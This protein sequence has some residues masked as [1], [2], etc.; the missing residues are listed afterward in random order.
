[1]SSQSV[2]APPS[3]LHNPP[4]SSF[5][6]SFNSKVMIAAM[7]ILFIVVVFVVGLHI[8][9]KWFWR[10]G[11]RSTVSAY[12]RYLWRRHAPLH[13]VPL[14]LIATA[15]AISVQS[16]LEAGLDPLIINSLPTFVYHPFGQDHSSKETL[17]ECAVCL[18]EF[19]PLEKG[20]LLPSCKHSFHVAC[21]DM[22]FRSHSTCP[23]CR[24]PVTPWT[25]ST[26]ISLPFRNILPASAIFQ[27]EIDQRTPTSFPPT[28]QTPC[29]NQQIRAILSVPGPTHV[30]SDQQTVLQ[31]SSNQ[32]LSPSNTAYRSALS[33]YKH[34]GC[35]SSAPCAICLTMDAGEEVQLEEASALRCQSLSLQRTDLEDSEGH[36]LQPAKSLSFRFAIKRL[37]SRDSS[38]G[39]GRIFPSEPSGASPEQEVESSMS[40]EFSREQ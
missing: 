32:Q 19:E 33:K 29:Q 16:T 21:I 34:E 3:M 27:H 24:A 40:R 13:G 30:R 28:G 14:D 23:L 2:A 7:V 39:R 25:P 38:K 26:L 4:P 5:G 35:A 17:L 36:G 9:A 37:L 18:S 6:Y 8:Y 31:Y 20:R 10:R 1:M 12:P 11:T 15:D 22:W